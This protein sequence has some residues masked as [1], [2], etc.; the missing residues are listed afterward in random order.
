MPRKFLLALLLVLLGTGILA[1]ATA[2]SRIAGLPGVPEIAGDVSEWLARAE[3]EVAA[4]TPIIGG[5]E[6]RIRWY[7]DNAGLRSD[8]VVVYLHG[9]SATRQEIAPVAEMVADGLEANLFETRLSG[10]GLEDGAL[11][12]ARAEDWLVDGVE[13]L[14]VGRLL[15]ER[16]VL[17]GT[18]T[19]A[20]LALALSDHELFS[21]VE[22]LVMVSPNFAPK[23]DT[24]GLLTSPGGPQ[25][26][27]LMLGETRSWSPANE[28]Q[29]RYW[30]TSYP[31]YALVEMM[32]L[33][34]YARA[35]IPADLSANVLTFYSPNDQV[36]NTDLIVESLPHIRSPRLET[37]VLEDS[38][39]PSNH[40]LAGDILAPQNSAKVAA[41]VIEFVKKGNL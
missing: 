32:R 1:F 19:G 8:Y 34:D 27:R 24:A 41:S 6:K 29:D 36:V 38:G 35:K 4:G 37:I 21:H 3:A 31:T 16:V 7:G 23:D 25:L 9:F 40:V 5:A 11:D 26:A 15:G 39:D 2:P 30:S 13:S 22:T 17:I 20:T 28:L 18:S 12:G 10:H 14:A 33:V